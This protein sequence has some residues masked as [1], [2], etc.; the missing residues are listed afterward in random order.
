MEIGRLG[1]CVSF[2]HYVTVIQSHEQQEQENKTKAGGALQWQ[3]RIRTGIQAEPN[4]FSFC[5]SE[6]SHTLV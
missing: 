2:M 3:Y 6:P 1:Q 4:V 5:H